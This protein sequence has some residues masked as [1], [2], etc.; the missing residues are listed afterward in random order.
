M[1]FKYYFQ[2]PKRRNIFKAALAGG[3]MD[4][5]SGN[6]H[7]FSYVE[8]SRIHFQRIQVVSLIGFPIWLVFA[9]VYSIKNPGLPGLFF[10]TG[11]CWFL[12]PPVC[13]LVTF[14]ALFQKYGPI[15]ARIL[16]RPCP[17]PCND[18]YYGGA[19]RS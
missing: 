7:C 9:W 12:L 16:Q 19:I 6:F 1:G 17:I 2:E 10:K 15:V 8:Y 11:R 4:S 18:V 3:G 14:L 13:F 5:I